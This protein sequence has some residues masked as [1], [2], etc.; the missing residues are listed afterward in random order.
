MLVGRK[1]IAINTSY[2]T[3]PWADYLIFSDD[4]WWRRHRDKLKNFRGKIVSASKVASGPNIWRR[5]NRRNPPG[6]SDEVGTV[7]VKWT[8]MT[9]A[10]DMAAQLGAARIVALGLDGKG[11]EAG[12]DKRGRPIIQTHHHEPHPSSNCM[13][14][15]K[16]QRSDLASFVAP[17]KARNIELLN[18]SPGSALGD[19]WP[20]TT[21]EKIL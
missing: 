2:Q 18:A 15:W 14:N 16:H 10:I 9:A 3:V 13:K 1:V 20:I 7:T 4:T 19:L 8:T 12:K 6:M 17:L 21:L 11:R 5:L